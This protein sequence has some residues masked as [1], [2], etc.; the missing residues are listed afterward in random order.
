MLLGSD[1]SANF[2]DSSV[3]QRF[4]K[5]TARILI[6]HSGRIFIKRS[7]DVIHGLVFRLK[8][9]Q[10]LIRERL[11]I[12]LP[13]CIA[14]GADRRYSFVGGC[15]PIIFKKLGYPTFSIRRVRRIYIEFEKDE[16][17]LATPAPVLWILGNRD[18]RSNP[19]SDI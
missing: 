8:T 14:I 3:V 7:E 12:S 2:R 19:R 11:E 13:N 1:D 16:T 18:R 6:P 5:L 9:L 17:S 15:A 10:V 4:L